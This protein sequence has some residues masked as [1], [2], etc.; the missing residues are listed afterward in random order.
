MIEDDFSDY[1]EESDDYDADDFE[2]WGSKR[3]LCD[4]A[5]NCYGCPYADECF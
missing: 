3:G 1:E 5:D 4:I 2:T